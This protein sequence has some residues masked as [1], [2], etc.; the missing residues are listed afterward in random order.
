[1]ALRVT[2]ELANASQVKQALRRYPIRARK[3]L[4]LAVMDAARILEAD[5]ANSQKTPVDTGRMVQSVGS[6]RVNLLTAMM[7][8]ATDYAVFVHEGTR[9][10][11]VNSPVFIQGVGWR[12]IGRHKGTKAQPF[13]E[14]ALRDGAQR[15]IDDRMVQAVERAIR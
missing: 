15:K 9:P 6:R 10:H 2:V 5:V 12:Y 7:F 13:V 3:E 4:S 11:D 14:W 1:M 8:V